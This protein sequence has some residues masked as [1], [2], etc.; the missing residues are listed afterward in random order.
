MSTTQKSTKHK[1]PGAWTQFLIMI[2]ILQKKK[3]AGPSVFLVKLMT[4]W[5]ALGQVSSF[6]SLLQV[7]V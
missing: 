5:A 1:E 3:S 7:I 2:K 6:R 4:L